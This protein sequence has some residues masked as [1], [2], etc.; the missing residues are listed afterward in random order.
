MNVSRAINKRY[1]C[2]SYQ[3]KPIPR[4]VLNK[5]L[6]AARLAPS[7]HNAQEW[8]FVIVQN[9]EK[10]KL[11]AQAAGQSFVG[12]APV[13]IAAVSTNPQDVMSGGSP[14][15]AVDLAIAV[16]HMTL[17][18][19]EEGL[20]SCWIGAFDQEQV[21][22]ILNIPEDCKIVVL[23]SIGYPANNAGPKTRKNLEEIICF[24]QFEE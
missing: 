1:S 13:I 14:T 18:A 2:R 24:D 17:V 23:L 21:K 9:E 7:A 4:K 11:L 12:Q 22:K 19:T 5:I 8:K 6:S 15:Y 16:D 3:Q 20:E 10:R